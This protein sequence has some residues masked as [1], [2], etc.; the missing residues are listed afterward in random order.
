[1]SRILCM[2]FEFVQHEVPHLQHV[3]HVHIACPAYSLSCLY[4]L[5]SGYATDYVIVVFDFSH[6]LYLVL[7]TVHE[8]LA[9]LNLSGTYLSCMFEFEWNL[10]CCIR[11]F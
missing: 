7:H 4:L 10:F 3:L 9:C 11:E 6:L 5:L 8:C 2:A 1:M